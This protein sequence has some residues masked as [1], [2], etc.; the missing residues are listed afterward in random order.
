MSMSDP[1]SDMLTRIRNGLKSGKSSV[2]MP[3]SGRKIAIAEVLEK[4]GYIS[5]MSVEG[6][7]A[8]RNLTIELKY[9]QNQPV[10]EEIRRI[11]TPSCRTYKRCRDL[12]PVKNG[13]GVALVSTSKGVLTDKEARQAG[14]GGE[15]ICTVF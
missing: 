7:R 1:I 13:L 9:Y 3:A 5:S 2:S 11:S 4:E 10:I 8:D 14:I 6:E 12:E 15:V